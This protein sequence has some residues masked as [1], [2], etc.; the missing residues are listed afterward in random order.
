MSS[1]SPIEVTDLAWLATIARASPHSGM[2]SRKFPLIPAIVVSLVSILA[3]TACQKAAKETAPA[4]AAAEKAPAVASKAPTAAVPD[5][6]QKLMGK[7]LRA[8]GGYVLELKGADITGVVQAA[9]FNPKSINVSRAI[10]MQGA[11]G[12]QVVV[13]LNDVGYPG[14]TYVLSYDP[15]A[16]RLFGQ[17]NQ[18]AM[19]Q[20]FDIEFMRQPKP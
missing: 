1:L 6:V 12:F 17:Y 2:P 4:A 5:A 3:A 15:K 19:Q 9:Y 20:S 13:E 10:W 11:N 18:P 14:A 7:W 8:D 16:D